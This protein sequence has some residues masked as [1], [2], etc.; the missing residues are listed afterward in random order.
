ME[1]KLR[2]WAVENGSSRKYFP[3][4]AEARSFAND[5]FDHNFDGIPFIRELLFTPNNLA[6]LLNV[7]EATS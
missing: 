3:A 2:L 7:L 5:A 6:G 4:E 1:D